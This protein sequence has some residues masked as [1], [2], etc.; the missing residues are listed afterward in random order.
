M[1]NLAD[2]RILLGITGGIAAYKSAE[3]ARRLREQGAHVR[4]VMTRAACSFIGPLTLQAL[5]GNPVHVELLDPGT[6][7]VMGHIEL[8]RWCDALLV[9]PA[10][11]DFLARLAAGRA[12]DLLATICLATASP[13][14]VAPAMNRQMWLAAATQDN[15]RLLGERGI[16]V[17]GPAEG[18]QACGETGPGRM[19][20]PPEM[21]EGV[22]ALF[23]S[24]RLAGL[25]V[26]ITAGPTREDLDPVRFISN[27]SSGRMGYAVARACTE[28]GARV[29]LVSGPVALAVPEG[30]D[31]VPA[32]SAGDMLDAVTARSADADIFI[33]AAAVADYRSATPSETKLKKTSDT[34]TLTLERTVDILEMVARSPNPPFTVGFAAETGDLER[35]ARE[36]LDRKGL[37]MV[38]ANQV[39]IPDVGF[40]SEENAL[41]VFWEGGERQLPRT[42]KGALARQLV[43]IIAERYREKNTTQDS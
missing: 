18:G 6:E 43:G 16:R 1:S 5:T 7:S 9:A 34:L 2:K 4:T 42:G 11:A 21:V 30:V 23:T 39:G 38:A 20:E 33:A 35:Y 37:D 19:L 10:T 29:T 32:Y 31:V 26:L 24:G 14:A 22:G 40:D 12:D 36:K 41:H 28:A 27:R 13:I 17:L 8:A 25:R 3:L 15:L